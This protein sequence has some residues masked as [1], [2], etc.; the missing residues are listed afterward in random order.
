VRIYS[1][2]PNYLRGGKKTRPYQ[3]LVIA[4]KKREQGKRQLRQESRKTNKIGRRGGETRTR[5]VRIRIEY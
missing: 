1:A 3:K 5:D 4:K 2:W